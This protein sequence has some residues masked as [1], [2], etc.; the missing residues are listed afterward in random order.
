MNEDRE[1]KQPPSVVT[2]SAWFP[3]TETDEDRAARLAE[4]LR[5]VRFEAR[6]DPHS[7]ALWDGYMVVVDGEPVHWPFRILGDPDGGGGQGRPA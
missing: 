2:R 3:H 1:A 5:T 6:P 7:H 4:V